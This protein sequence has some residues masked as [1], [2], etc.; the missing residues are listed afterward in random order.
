MENEKWYLIRGELV[1]E[2]C[3][4]GVDIYVFVE[5]IMKAR[6]KYRKMPGVRRDYE[7][8]FIREL[9]EEESA[10]LEKKIIEEGRIPLEK[11]RRVWYKDLGEL[12]SR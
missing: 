11:A 7:P 3:G 1:H 6:N 10:Q 12:Q 5:D 2:D 8:I 9:S 4:R